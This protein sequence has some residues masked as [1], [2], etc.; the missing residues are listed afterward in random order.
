[1]NINEQLCA[2]VQE[3]EKIVEKNFGKEL[4]S[5]K[6]CGYEEKVY[7]CYYTNEMRVGA[8][9]SVEVR[10]IIQTI[11]GRLVIGDPYCSGIT[12]FIKL[13]GFL[14]DIEN[15]REMVADNKFSGF[16][17]EE[18]G[19][20]ETK[21]NSELEIFRERILTLVEKTI[22]YKKLYIAAHPELLDSEITIY[23]GFIKDLEMISNGLHGIYQPGEMSN[24]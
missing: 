22:E 4:L 20:N 2:I 5:E 18:T 19:G 8:G 3:I 15:L 14:A 6:R 12:S 10:I 17:L 7:V 9:I 11:K 1:M 21:Q 16:E 13:S 23:K 24:E